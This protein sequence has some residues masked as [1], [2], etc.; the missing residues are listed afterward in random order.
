MAAV[1]IAIVGGLPGILIGI[2]TLIAT[3]RNGNRATSAASLAAAKAI[4]AKTE[5]KLTRD[6][7]RTNTEMTSQVKQQTNGARERMDAMLKEAMSMLAAHGRAI[8]IL[9]EKLS[10][11]ES[12]VKKA[13]ET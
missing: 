13:K 8:G 3:I 12:E 9:Q 11:A 10:A 7:L 4:E 5:A 2:G 6:E 1:I